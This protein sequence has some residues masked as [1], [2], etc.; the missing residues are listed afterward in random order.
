MRQ[1]K[2]ENLK[3][4]IK[5][6][7]AENWVADHSGRWEHAEW[8]ALLEQLKN[9]PY[10]PMSENDVGLYLEA[11][12]R[13]YRTER[14]QLVGKTE[15]DTLSSALW[16]YVVGLA[17]VGLTT[18]FFAGGSHT[19]VVGTLLPL[20]VA[21]VGGTG[22]LYLAGADLSAPTAIARLRWLGRG[23]GS[24]ALSCLL[25]SAAGIWLRLNYAHSASTNELANV[26]HDKVQDS[27]QLAVLRL[28]LQ[29]LGISPKEQ[30]HI[31]RTASDAMNDAVR[32]VPGEYVRK[33]SSEALGLSADLRLLREKAVKM[34][35]TVPEEADKLI[36]ALDLFYHQTEPWAS[37]AMPRP[38][39]KNAVE[40]V[41]YWMSHVAMPKD[42]A[43]AEWL[44]RGGF[45]TAKLDKLFQSLRAEFELRDDLDWEL[46]GSTSDRLDKFLQSTSNP[47]KVVSNSDDILPAI[48]MNQP[49]TSKA[50]EHKVVDAEN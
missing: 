8:E 10:W 17:F 34:Q 37:S 49:E 50:T 18:G 23:F 39:Y 35:L 40:T 31:L 1:A 14:D 33:V 22:G 41:W 32:P 36:G 15:G 19:P 13:K 29:M 6:E 44:R 12:A 21:L 47:R 28:K 24:F 16:W 9:S 48:D 7:D 30:D 5:S 4:W 11:L 38:L 43:T 45:D 2:F 20:L 27:I 42:P 46:G 26:W 3:R 25:G